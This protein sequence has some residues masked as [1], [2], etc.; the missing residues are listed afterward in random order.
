MM[1]N[2]LGSKSVA[3]KIMAKISPM[4]KTSSATKRMM[5]LVLK[6]RTKMT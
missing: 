4:T 5:I 3:K 1:D 2:K 6:T